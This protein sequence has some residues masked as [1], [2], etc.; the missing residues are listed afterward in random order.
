MM[1]IIAVAAAILM[2]S[3]Q[4]NEV[5]PEYV[6]N[7]AKT[8]VGKALVEKTT[9]IASLYSDEETVITEGLTLTAVSYLGMDGCPMRIWFLKAE[10]SNDNICLD[11]MWAGEGF[12]TTGSALTDMAKK[13]DSENHFVW[14][15]TNSDFGSDAQKGPQGIFHH[16]GKCYKGT[17]NVLTSSPE[18]P[19]CFFYMTPDKKVRMA[20]QA[21]YDDVVANVPDIVEAGAGGPLL[22]S[23]GVVQNIPYQVDGLSDRHP[24]TCI[25]VG[26]DGT[27]VWVMLAD[28]RRYT[29]S[30]GLQFPAMCEIM[31]AVGCHDLMNL[32]G[33]GSS[34]MIVR[35]AKDSK[36][37]KV[38]NWTNDNGG[39]ERILYTGIQF[40]TKK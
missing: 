8:A 32:D 37:F 28:G 15:A 40:V 10:L 19:R 6:G 38:I 14:A 24:R 21:D 29:W 39:E 17:F 2:V 33:G 22:I 13:E 4:E 7:E 30:N 12:R 27:T 16:N 34:E 5:Q 36:D 31:S 11:Q 1:N 9:Q 26:K 35:A 20:D 18:R 25:G 3:C 23:N